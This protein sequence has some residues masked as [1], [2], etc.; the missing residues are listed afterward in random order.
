MRTDLL[1]CD[2][3]STNSFQLLLGH[4]TISSNYTKCGLLHESHM[5]VAHSV[6]MHL[7]SYYTCTAIARE[8]LEAKLICWSYMAM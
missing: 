1:L 8:P 5:H 6:H 2:R 3:L 4:L 7:P